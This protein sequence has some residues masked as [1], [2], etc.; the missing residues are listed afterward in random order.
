M[1]AFSRGWQ[2][3]LQAIDMARKDPDLLKPSLYGFLVNGLISLVTLIPLAIL[4]FVFGGGQFS[5]Y[6]F[7]ILGALVY[8][9]E[10]LV[11]YIFAGMTAKLVHSYLTEGDGRMEDAWAVV[12]RDIVD[13]MALAAASTVIKVIEDFIRQQQRRGGIGG[14]IAGVLASVLETVWT[15][16]TYFVLPAMVIE[17]LN[18][19][20]S[21]KRATHLISQNLLLVA[22]SEIGIRAVTG[23]LSFL[24]ILLGVLVGGGI[25]FATF[26]LGT[27]ALIAGAVVAA[28]I[29]GLLISLVTIFGTYITTAYY[30]TLF[31]WATNA[32]QAVQEGQSIQSVPAPAPLAAVLG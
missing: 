11:S 16:A 6:I 28:I 31:V 3:F 27:V 32:E 4:G 12:K 29:L 19:G 24:V 22:V 20:Q 25:V 9:V 18:L 13:L 8:F 5:Q 7:I 23:L 26:Q 30:T 14:A 21:L 2:F 1:R 17:D 15:V 10:Y